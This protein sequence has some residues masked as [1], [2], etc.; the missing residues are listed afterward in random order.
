MSMAA[1]PASQDA[2]LPRRGLYVIAGVTVIGPFVGSAL[3]L[4]L[5]CLYGV[6]GTALAIGGVMFVLTALGISAGFHRYFEPST[7]SRNAIGRLVR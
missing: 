6:S 4:V 3:A 1:N 5:A 2:L 7:S